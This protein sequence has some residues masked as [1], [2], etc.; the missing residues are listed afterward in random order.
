MLY[1]LFVSCVFALFG[2][3]QSAVELACK[4]HQRFSFG[5]HKNSLSDTRLHTPARNV[6]AKALAS[7]PPAHVRN[8]KARL[9]RTRTFG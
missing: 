6:I 3:L 4:Y 7:I 8:G 1:L 5:H 2:V 9:Q